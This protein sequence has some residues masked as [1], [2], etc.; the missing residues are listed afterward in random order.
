MSVLEFKETDAEGVPVDRGDGGDGPFGR[1]GGKKIVELF[2][3]L[4]DAAG[5]TVNEF[6]VANCLFVR[7]DIFC[8]DM[9]NL[10]VG[11]ARLVAELVFV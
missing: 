7:D 6:G 1:E 11:V 9:V 8:D 3:V 4:E 2:F 10:G 5:Q